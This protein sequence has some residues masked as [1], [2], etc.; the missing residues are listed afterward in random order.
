MNS[1]Y[2]FDGKTI[3]IAEN[4]E[5]NFIFYKEVFRKTKAEVIWA[6]NGIQAI[7]ICNNNKKIN[8]IIMDIQMPQLNGIEAAIA[9]KKIMDVPIVVL[10]AFA[11]K[12]IHEK[13]IKANCEDFITKPVKYKELLMVANKYLG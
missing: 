10:T 12:S 9:I 6:K 4:D 13:C 8:L 5:T 7:E 3:L 11:M 1:D 2:T